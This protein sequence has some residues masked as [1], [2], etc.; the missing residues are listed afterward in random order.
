MLPGNER[1]DL[2]HGGKI[3]M[4]P[5]AL[6]QLS[7]LNVQYP[8]LFKLTNPATSRTTHCG[9]LEFIADEGKVYLPYWMMQNLAIDQGGLLMVESATLPVGD[10]AKFQPHSKDFVDLT[11]PKAVLESK[12]RNFACLSTGDV[13]A[14][15]YNNKTYEVS[16][17]ETKP[18]AAV[19]VIE[20]DLNVDFAPY[21]GY[22]EPE[23]APKNS[24]AGDDD[25]EEPMDLTDLIPEPKGFVAFGGEGSRLDGKKKRTTSET[26]V[27]K[28]KQEYVRGIPDYDYEIGL[29]KFIRSKPKK[30]GNSSDS[31][32]KDI[33]DFEAFKGEGKSLRQSRK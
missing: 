2:E 30:N 23:R 5:S 7:R 22:K 20:C 8:M 9:V 26:E 10:F 16:V 13:I 19:S 29:L 18:A 33:D 31:A 15:V 4:P 21:V 3:I 12:L 25:D 6:D 32:N 1:D 27:P 28:L 24:S 14:I 17:L 11:N